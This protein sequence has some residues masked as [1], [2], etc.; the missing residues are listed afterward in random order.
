MEYPRE[1]TVDVLKLS[2]E[3]TETE[4]QKF[5][6]DI[7][8]MYLYAVIK[9]VD[10]EEGMEVC[11]EAKKVK[12]TRVRI[13]TEDGKMIEIPCWDLAVFEEEKKTIWKFQSY[14]IFT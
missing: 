5:L 3:G 10:K 9:R 2:I 13:Q 1:V 6:E 4:V 7:Q 11:C 8:K 14:D 12:H